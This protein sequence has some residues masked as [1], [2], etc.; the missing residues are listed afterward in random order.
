[1]RGEFRRDW[2]TEAFFTGHLGPTD[3]RGHQNTA[4]IGGVWWF[5]NEQGAWQEVRRAAPRN[6]RP[7]PGDVCG[8]AWLRHAV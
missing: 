3:L 8:H 7:R 4:L 6:D 5:G 2:S 1:M